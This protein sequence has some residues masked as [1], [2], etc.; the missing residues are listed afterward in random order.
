[1]QVTSRS[2]EQPSRQPERKAGPGLEAGFCQQP[3]C[4]WSSREEPQ[5]CSPAHTLASDSGLRSHEK[6]HRS[7]FKTPVCAALIQQPQEASTD[8]LAGRGAPSCG[9]GF[10]TGERLENLETHERKSPGC[11]EQSAVQEPMGT[12]TES[13]GL[14]MAAGASAELWP[15]VGHRGGPGSHG[16]P[17]RFLSQGWKEQHGGKRRKMPR[18][19]PDVWEVPRPSGSQGSGLGALAPQRHCTWLAGT[20][21]SPRRKPGAVR[22]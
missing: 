4:A 3:G 9:S 12:Q 11:L 15:P 14:V 2:S 10:G 7:C 6:I 21:A 18:A 13:W 19:A 8:L 1:M 22:P 17:G 5:G 16:P 20:P